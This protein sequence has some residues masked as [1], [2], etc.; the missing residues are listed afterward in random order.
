MLLK[1]LLFL[2]VVEIIFFIFFGDVLGFFNVILWIITT[3]ILGFWLLSPLKKNQL[4]KININDQPIDWICKRLS[5]VLLIIPGFFTDFI[6]I[7]ILFKPFRIIIWSLI[8]K[9]ILNFSKDFNFKTNK[10]NPSKN[11]E[12]IIDADYKNLDD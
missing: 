12:K 6:G 4:H 7:I 1:F 8:P 10:S 2:P 5:G 3:G 11:N 9:R